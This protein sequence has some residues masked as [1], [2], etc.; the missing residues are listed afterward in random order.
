MKNTYL[1]D[2]HKK[3]GAKLVDFAGFLMPIQYEL[4]IIKEH[5]WVRSSCGIFDVSH[6]GQIILRGTRASEMLS[7]L[8]PTNFCQAKENQAKYTVLLN[9]DCGIIDDLIITKLSE[10]SFFIVL[11]ASRVDVDLARFEQFISQYS[12]KIEKLENRSLVAIQGPKATKI[13]ESILDQDIDSIEYMNLRISKYK[14]DEIF[15]SRTGYTGEDGF[16][17]SIENNKVEALWTSLLE[18]NDVKAIG[19]GARDSLRL[20]VGYPLYGNDLS[21]D[22]NLAEVNLKWVINSDDFIAKD[23]LLAEP[24]K[25]RKGIKLLEKGIARNNMEVFSLDKDKIGVITSAGYSPSLENSIGQAY[26]N[27]GYH[28]LGTKV[29]VKIRKDYKEAEITK[30]CHLQPRVKKI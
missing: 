2:Q 26:I 1:I 4:G 6:M 25:F 18:N 16:E 13:L 17:V 29:L 23:K 10:G 14:G 11:N 7:F 20:E 15:I 27:K 21:E 9:D 19:L 30:I 3:L 5:S 12:C 8:T 24:S 22:L 28:K